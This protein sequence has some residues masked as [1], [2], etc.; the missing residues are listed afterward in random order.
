[1]DSSNVSKEDLAKNYDTPGLM[2]KGSFQ[3]IKIPNSDSFKVEMGIEKRFSA[4][5]KKV[6]KK[7]FKV[8][9]AKPR[10]LN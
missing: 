7:E 3:N 8:I 4:R 5:N 10:S 1:M 6:K 9:Q 2:K